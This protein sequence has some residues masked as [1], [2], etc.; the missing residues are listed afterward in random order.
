LSNLKIHA[1]PG[2]ELASSPQEAVRYAM[3]RIRPSK[4]VISGRRK[5]LEIHPGLASFSWPHLSQGQRIVRWVLHRQARAQ[6]LSC[7]YAALAR[8]ETHLQLSPPQ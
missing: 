4:D 6:S 5:A 7:V 2:I 3:S 8:P 1:F